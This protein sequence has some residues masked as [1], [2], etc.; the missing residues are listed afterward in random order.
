MAIIHGTIESLKSLKSELRDK[1]ISRFSSVKEIQTFLSNYNSEKEE[2]IQNAAKMLEE[3]YFETCNTLQRNV[4]R[5]NEISESEEIRIDSRIRDLQ[6]KISVIINQKNQNLIKKI[7]SSIQLYFLKNKVEYFKKNKSKL[8]QFSV[9]DISIQI[10]ASE[11][12]IEKFET[13]KIKFVEERAQSKLEELEYIRQVVEGA[14][15]LISGAIGENLVVKEIK[16]LSDDYVLINDFNLKFSDPIFYKKYNQRI[17]SI[18]IDHLLLS[19]A[20]IFIIETKNWSRSSVDSLS[21]RS[22]IEQIERANYALFVYFSE[23]LSLKGHHWGE[24]QIPIRNLIVMI[25]N[26]PK[27]E[28][29]YV[30]IKLLKELNTYLSYFE[31]VLTA[32]QLHRIAN[33]LI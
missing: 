22:P 28:F 26:K 20:G 8:I 19:K 1:Q 14:K 2:T 23:K 21:L 4:E 3:E 12:F 29:K 16:K 27:G 17:H 24:Q 10:Q 32:A 30:K 6:C 33:K 25:N 11:A 15:N 9:N 5:K 13:D 31:P 7:I 18:Q